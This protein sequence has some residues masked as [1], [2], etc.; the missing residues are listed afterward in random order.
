MS[1][2]NFIILISAGQAPP[3]GLTPHAT[4]IH[5]GMPGGSEAMEWSGGDW[6]EESDFE[7]LEVSQSQV[8]H[9]QS[10]LARIKVECQHWKEL[11]QQ[12]VSVLKN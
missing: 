10:E 7:F 2:H 5:V 1:C 6:N 3:T 4:G 8:S 11:A 12:R 9:L